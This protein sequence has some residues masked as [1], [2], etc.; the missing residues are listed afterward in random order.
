M[1]GGIRIFAL[2]CLI[3]VGVECSAQDKGAVPQPANEEYPSKPVRIIV[4]SAPGGGL[5]TFSRAI[6]QKLSEA[7]GG[8]RFLIDNRP[9]G[10]GSVGI[11]VLV[12]SSPDG[13][14]LYFGGGDLTISGPMKRV[15]YDMRTAV[16]PVVEI[17]ASPYFLVISSVLPVNS[18]KELIAYAKAN[19]GVLNY[20]SSGVGSPIHLGMELLALKAGI[21]MIHVPY[22]GNSSAYP[23]LTSGQIHVMLSNPT[24]AMPLVKAGKIKL[25]A[26][27]NGTRQRAFPDLP[28]LSETIPDYEHGNTAG[29]YAPA[30]L[31]LPITMTLNR[32]ITKAVN[33]PDVKARIESDGS[34]VS[35]PNTPAE[36][37]EKYLK[38]ISQWEDVISKTGMKPEELKAN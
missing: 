3:S 26:T 5:D 20:G 13:Y 38:R 18:V 33:T 12:K 1:K 35:G 31:P 7:F 10:S 16:T 37:K 25:L 4:S 30:G 27:T 29:I 32:S 8:R 34:E 21:K 9:N 15:P 28:A 22:K 23:D 6:G 14:T 19:P 2:A 24:S 11:D 17:A 36:F